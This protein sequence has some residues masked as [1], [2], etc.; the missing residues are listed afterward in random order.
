[1]FAQPLKTSFPHLKTG[2]LLRMA[3]FLDTGMETEQSYNVLNTELDSEQTF[4]L[5]VCG[6]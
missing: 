1:M 6:W 2:I 5:N 4:F 3:Y